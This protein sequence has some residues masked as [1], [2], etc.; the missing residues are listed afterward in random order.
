MDMPRLPRFITKTLSVRLSLTVVFAMAVLICSLTVMLHFSRKAI[1]EEALQKAMQTLEGTAQRIDNIMLSIEQATGNQYF[2]LLPHLDD[3]AKVSAYSRKLVESNRYIDGC[4]IALKPYYYKDRELFMAYFHHTTNSPDS[5]II[6]S[7]TFGNTP[8][9]EQLW[10]TNP[11]TSKK[12]GWMR[13][14]DISETTG[15]ALKT[16]CLPIPGNDGNPIGI[17][18]VDVSLS[19]L[20]Q[21]IQAT[22]PSPNSYCTLLAEDGTYIVHPDSNKLNHQ[23]ILAQTGRLATPSMKLAAQA[24]VSGGT[25]YRPFKMNGIDYYVFYKPFIRSSVAGRTME[26]LGWSV[27]IIYPEDDI[28]G[29]YNRLLYYVLGIAIVGLL[30]LFIF[31]RI[32]IHH[33]LQPLALLTRS[34]QHIADGDYEVIIPDSRQHDEIG[35]LQNH[36]RQMQ[37]ALAAN[38]DELE[39]LKTTLQERGESLKTAY[40]KAQQADKMKTA[41]LHNMTDKMAVPADAIFNDVDALCDFGVHDLEKRE[42]NHLADDIQQHGDTIA[43]LLNDLL[44]ASEKQ[45]EKG[46]HP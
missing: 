2:S 26:K 39:Q 44:R 43:D 18:G 20:S 42:I 37:F 12:V 36:F 19:L 14:M 4:A 13:P 27:G 15:E 10:Y 21:I 1:K 23:S 25:G 38:F 35:S 46:G 33:Q 40:E 22:K 30:L 9:T 31:C 8:Y 29:D 16:F 11:M 24:M 6:Q 3:S 45:M 17:I 5:P 7:E 41:F 32:I 34:A 28:F